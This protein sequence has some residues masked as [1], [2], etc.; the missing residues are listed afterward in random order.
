MVLAVR[1]VL[2]AVMRPDD[3]IGT[4]AELNDTERVRIC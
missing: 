1:K 4:T 2:V 3:Y